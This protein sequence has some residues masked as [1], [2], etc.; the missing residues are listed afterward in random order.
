MITAMC[1]QSGK[2]YRVKDELAGRRAKC[3]CG[4]AFV[5][6][7]LASDSLEV[8]AAVTATR[9]SPPSSLRTQSDH[10]A[11]ALNSLSDEGEGTGPAADDS[12]KSCPFCAETIAAKAIKCR[13]CGEFL[14][15]RST[16]PAS[17]AAISP[18][19]VQLPYSA[20]AA[21]ER[22]GRTMRRIGK[23]K[24]ENAALGV[25]EGTIKYGLATVSA[26]VAVAADGENRSRVVIQAKG[27]DVWGAAARNATARF[28]E[29]MRNL[30][31]PGYK[32]DRRGIPPLVIV[33][34]VLVFIV[35]LIFL[36]RALGWALFG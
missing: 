11:A 17:S 29:T 2:Q 30:D 19:E 12:V 22:V 3:S 7:P 24:S 27:Q 15:G 5:V 20:Q 34:S 13:H 35:L 21:M 8:L 36:D 23:V 26:R 31:T 6:P 4:A 1:G 28:F 9:R 25:V 18:N 33:A 10:L 32:A 16:L 14:D